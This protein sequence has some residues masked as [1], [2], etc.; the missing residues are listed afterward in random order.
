[1]SIARVLP[2][3]ARGWNDAFCTCFFVEMLCQANYDFG[4]LKST[5]G[6]KTP[7]YLIGSGAEGLVVEVGGKGKGRE[8][9]K[10]VTAY[11]KLIFAH[12]EKP[13][14]GRIPLFLAGFMA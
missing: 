3:P 12:T 11:R 1:M 2:L 9:F 8:Q 14:K 13:E 6:A 7:D 10:G 4:Y 5:R